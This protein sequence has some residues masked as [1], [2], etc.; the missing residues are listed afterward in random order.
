MDIDSDQA[1]GSTPDP[2]A[3][4]PQSEPA[5]DFDPDSAD[6]RVL[7]LV[8]SDRRVLL[9]GGAAGQLARA[10]RERGCSVIGIEADPET[11]AIAAPHCERAIVGDLDGIDLD[12]ELAD[13]RFHVIVAAQ[14]LDRVREPAALLRR[15]RSFLLSDGYLVISLHNVAHGSVRLALLEGRFPYQRV[16]PL[17]EAHL[18]FFTRESIEELLDEA[19]LGI[20]ELYRQQMQIED[21]EVPFDRSAVPAEVKHALE[22]DPDALTY[23]FVIKAIPFDVEGLREVQRR[24]RE[25][26]Q[27]NARLR[28]TAAQRENQLSGREA[29]LRAALVD[30]HDQLLRRDDEIQRLHDE[31]LRLH[32]RLER[33]LNSPPARL[34]A[35]LRALPFI[36]QLAA[37]RGA[38]Y[39]AAVREAQRAA[40]SASEPPHG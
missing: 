18:R 1:T 16:G 4:A 38:A 28:E 8:G 40:S 32:V 10:L 15:L 2:T 6:A 35:R 29:Q 19:E 11:A 25:L 37:R 27:E 26:V 5:L 34:Y 17:D 30:A 14:A 21:S 23:R 12:A 9:I 36:R 24:M 33:A 13:E 22:H 20:A 39:E 3:E 31:L 7:R